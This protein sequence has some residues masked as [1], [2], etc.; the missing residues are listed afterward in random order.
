MNAAALLLPFVVALPHGAT[1]PPPGALPATARVTTLDRELGLALVRMPKQRARPR[2]AAPAGRARRALRGARRA[3][4]ARRRGLRRRL[5]ARMRSPIPSWRRAIHL[6]KRSAAGIVIGMADS[7]VDDD[8]LA[9]L[10]R[11]CCISRRAG[12]ACPRPDRARHRGRQHPG[13]EPP[14]RGRRRPRAGRDAAVGAHRQVD[15]GCNRP[16]LEHGLVEAFGWLRRNGAQVVNV[17]ATAKPID[18]RSIESLRALQLSG[19]LVVAAVG[20]ERS[21]SQAPVPGLAA[22]RARR[23]RAAAGL[24]DAGLEGARRAAPSSISWRRRTGSGSSHR[25][26]GLEDLRD[27]VHTRRH[28]VRDPDRDRRRGDGVGVA[29]RLDGSRGRQRADEHRHAARQLVP[30]INSG[31]GVL[32]VS[33]ALHAQKLPDSHEPNDWVAAAWP[34][35]RCVRAPSWSP[36]SAGPATSVDIYTVDVPAGTTARPSCAAAAMGS[37]SAAADRHDGRH[38]PGYRAS[39]RRAARS[40]CPPAARCWSSRAGRARGPTGWRSSG[41][42]QGAE[43]ASRSASPIRP[44]PPVRGPTTR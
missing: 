40:P 31:Y 18:V 9:P 30:S 7:G 44:S 8:R 33:N 42:R 14:R 32:N 10:S 4:P 2:V 35:G 29:S 20:N 5:R 16:R 13:R 34:S 36:A 38:A 6:S 12:S 27:R 19:A 3:G 23:R 22:G 17:S 25:A 24:L 15:A 43:A 41:G 26:P 39:A 28:V 11:R 21:A 1:A 37:R